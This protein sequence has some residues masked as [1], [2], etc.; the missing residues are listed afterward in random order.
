MLDGL[1]FD[2]F[3]LTDDGFGCAEVGVGWRHVVQALV[4]SP[5]IAR[6]LNWS[7]TYGEKHADRFHSPQVAPADP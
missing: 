6:N 4:V 2:P 1:P 3:A 7:T 5:V